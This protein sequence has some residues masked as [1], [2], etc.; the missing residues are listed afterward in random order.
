MGMVLEER[1]RH[2][3][4][5]KPR[6]RATSGSAGAQE[7]GGKE[8]NPGCGLGESVALCLNILFTVDR[9]LTARCSSGCHPSLHSWLAN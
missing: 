8:R 1:Q 7:R 6:L 2:T 4:C 3:C 9:R 5:G